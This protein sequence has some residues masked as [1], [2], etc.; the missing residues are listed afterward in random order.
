M[1][2]GAGDAVYCLTYISLA[3]LFGDIGKQCRPGSDAAGHA[4]FANIPA[5]CFL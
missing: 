3:S 5:N 1:L 4:L 2:F